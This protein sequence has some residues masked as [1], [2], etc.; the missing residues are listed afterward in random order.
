[1]ISHNTFSFNVYYIN[2]N[3]FGLKR[4]YFKVIIS[5]SFSLHIICLHIVPDYFIVFHFLD[6]FCILNDLGMILG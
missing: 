4:I 6:C 1:M 2:F 3:V 5:F